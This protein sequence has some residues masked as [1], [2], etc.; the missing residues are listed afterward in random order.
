MTTT[1][2]RQDLNLQSWA[3]HCFG[4]PQKRWEALA[5]SKV[6]ITGAGTGF[7]L[8]M[9]AALAAAGGQVFLSGRRAAKLEEALGFIRSL[10]ISAERCVPIP[11]D[12]RDET[13]VRAAVATIGASAGSLFGLINNAALPMRDRRPAPL[14]A[15]DATGWRDL[16][17]TNVTGPWL[18]T[19]AAL[20]LLASASAGRVIFVT[21]EA[22]WAFTPGHGPYNMSKAA[23]NNLGASF[24]AECAAAYP[25]RDLQINVL[26]PGEARTEM[27]QASDVSP[28][29]VVPM[30]LALLSHPSGGPNGCFFHRDGRHLAFA[31]AVP[32]AKP[33]L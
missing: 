5:K 13:S 24:A 1:A 32:Y 15:I 26:V 31:Y 2:I 22:G 4:L 10:G 8:S 12:V 21:S 28:D 25:D 17:E 11:C 20:P 30:T 23:L 9:A 19:R 27:N 14:A 33:L 18:V 7:G 29:A 6:W 3:K 16:V